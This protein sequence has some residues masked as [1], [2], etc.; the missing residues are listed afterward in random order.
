MQRGVL[1]ALAAPIIGVVLWVILWRMG[2]IASLVSFAIVYL[3]VWLYKKGAGVDI[4]SRKAAIVSLIIAIV[5]VILAFL[6]G[7]VSDGTSFYKQDAQMSE[8]ALLQEGQFWS[9]MGE[10]FK[11]LSFWSAYKMDI[12]I[13]LAFAA[14]GMYSTIKDLFVSSITSAKTE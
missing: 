12:L 9:L 10:S 2:F 11:Y 6:A 4:L 5:G 8:W 13:S 7:V 14:L 3:T 1:F